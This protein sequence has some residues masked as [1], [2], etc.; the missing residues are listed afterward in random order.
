[1]IRVRV[2]VSRKRDVLCLLLLV[3][4]VSD[5]LCLVCSPSALGDPLC[6]VCSPSAFASVCSPSA[7]RQCVTSDGVCTSET[8]VFSRC[9]D[10]LAT[11]M[12]VVTVDVLSLEHL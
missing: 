8:R 3:L 7:M 2:G 11:T 5:P 4:V 6:L 9:D 12:F 10:V 1:M